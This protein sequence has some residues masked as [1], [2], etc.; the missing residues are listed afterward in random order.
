M[1]SGA[2][3]VNSAP[4]A[5]EKC[6]ALGTVKNKVKSVSYTAKDEIIPR[7][8][9]IWKLCFNQIPDGKYLC[10]ASILKPITVST[11]GHKSELKQYLKN[12]NNNDILKFSHFHGNGNRDISS[13]N[14]EST[15]KKT[16]FLLACL[17]LFKFSA[18]LNGNK[19]TV[20]FDSW[21]SENFISRKLA[22]DY[23]LRL[24]N[25]KAA[26]QINLPNGNFLK[27]EHYVRCNFLIRFFRCRV[28]LRVADMAPLVI[29]GIP[30]LNSWNPQ[31]NWRSR[32]MSIRFKNE[33]VKIPALSASLQQLN[34]TYTTD[35]IL[36]LNLDNTV[37]ML[38]VPL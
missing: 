1:V 16:A 3:S 9:F 20:I 15:V 24:H 29:F 23:N 22:T 12:N 32:I 35:N 5:F 11:L 10:G 33:N 38:G 7:K 19:T 31:I 34:L 26:S 14:S 21:A 30:F 13:T 36:N 8:Q 2:F 18:V 37:K 17:P 25:L 27:V 6:A 28:C 4:T